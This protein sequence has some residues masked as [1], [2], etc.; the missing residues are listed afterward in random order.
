MDRLPDSHGRTVANDVFA[1]LD[2]LEAT[3]VGAQTDNYGGIPYLRLDDEARGLFL[4]WRTEIETR[5][6]SGELHMAV[7]SHL[8]KYRKLVPGLALIIHLAEHKTGPIGKHSM[9]QALAWAQYL[10][11][12]AKR[13]YTSGIN[14]EVAAAKAIIAKVRGGQLPK[15]F[16][17]R[18]IW[19]SGW[20][21]LTDREQV[22]AGLRMLTDL[23]WLGASRMETKGR[24]AT[25]F[26][27][28]PRAF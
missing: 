24:T 28:N 13:L 9:L 11:T 17:S 8:A 22:S 6:R 10:E 19:R 15:T 25:T 20:A 14:Q 27:A 5:L 7:E 18:D 2:T 23:D 26:T 1:Y 4:E 3:S 21:N 12:H 16:S